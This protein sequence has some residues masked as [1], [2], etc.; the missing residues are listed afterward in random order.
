[1]SSPK[2]GFPGPLSPDTPPGRFQEVEMLEKLS[3]FLTDKKNE[4]QK[5][6][7]Q[8]SFWKQKKEFLESVLT[9]YLHYWLAASS[10]ADSGVFTPNEPI[11]YKDAF[12]KNLQEIRVE[13][14]Q[15]PAAHNLSGVSP[16]QFND[17]WVDVIQDDET[18][19]HFFNDILST[20]PSI[21]IEN[22]HPKS[23]ILFLQLLIIYYAYLAPLTT[24]GITGR[25]DFFTTQ[26]VWRCGAMISAFDWGGG[27]LDRTRKST[28]KKR[29]E[30]SKRKMLAIEEYRQLTIKN[31][32]SVNA[33]A[34]IINKRLAN[35]M[36]KPPSVKSI[37]RY[38]QQE[39]LV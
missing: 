36:K 11:Y 33:I 24:S 10:A 30:K 5:S 13:N 26:L 23:L 15:L 9:E 6:S 25:I 2:G 18:Q 37:T 8:L 22:I 3:E 16:D 34:T 17:F 38:L 35:K 4:Y 21:E 12:G 29:K 14:L 20:P 31:D 19:I 32:L 27:H 39:G 28:E 1:V 7:N